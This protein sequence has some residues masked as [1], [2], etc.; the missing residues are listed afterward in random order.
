MARACRFT[1]PYGSRQIWLDG[2]PF[3]DIH[4][5][6]D[7]NGNGPRPSDVDDVAKEIKKLLCGEKKSKSS[8][9][10]IFDFLKKKP[11]QLPRDPRKMAQTI[12]IVPT[13]GGRMMP[14]RGARRRRRRRR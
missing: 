6:V 14:L 12:M 13:P 9:A 5:P 4:R 8:L 11:K 7:R 10:G 2:K 1:A 3:I